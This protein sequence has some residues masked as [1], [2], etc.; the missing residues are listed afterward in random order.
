MCGR[1]TLAMVVSSAFMIDA[2]ITDAVMNR[3]VVVSG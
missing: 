3:R 2:A 1:A